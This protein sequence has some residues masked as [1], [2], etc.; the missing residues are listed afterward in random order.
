MNRTRRIRTRSQPLIPSLRSIL[1]ILSIPPPR[2]LLSTL[3]TGLTRVVGLRYPAPVARSFISRVKTLRCRQARVRQLMLELAN[4]LGRG[5][6]SGLAAA[7]R[8]RRLQD[9][10][11]AVENELDGLGHAHPAAWPSLDV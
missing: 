9:D 10:L 11:A 4:S 6:I 3:A 5:D 8:L 1:L 7:R 2:P